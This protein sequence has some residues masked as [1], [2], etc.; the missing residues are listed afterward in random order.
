MQDVDTPVST[1]RERG[2]DGFLTLLNPDRNRDDLFSLTSL[3]QAERFFDGNFVERVHRHFDVGQFDTRLV[4]LDADLDV[5]IDD[6]LDGH[7]HLHGD[8]D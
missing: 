1:H 2:A 8:S 5:V 4:G 6:P 7:E 3:S